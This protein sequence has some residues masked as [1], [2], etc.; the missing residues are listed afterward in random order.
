MYKVLFLKIFLRQEKKLDKEV[1]DRIAKVV[2]E[3]IG[4]PYAGIPLRGDLKRYWKK[5]VGKYRII[6]K[7]DEKEKAVIFFDVDLRK[8]IY[9]R[10]KKR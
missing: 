8:R 6:Y 10:M 3:I 4:K 9:D 7:I 2:K 5:K 1:K